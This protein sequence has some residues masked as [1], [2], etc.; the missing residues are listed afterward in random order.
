MSGQQGCA[1]NTLLAHP[2]FFDRF[3]MLCYLVQLLDDGEDEEGG[4]EADDYEHCPYYPWLY[5]PEEARYLYEEVAE[6]C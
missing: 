5:S 2:C 4:D 3:Y 1:N 6:R